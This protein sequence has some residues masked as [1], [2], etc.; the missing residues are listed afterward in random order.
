ML[1]VFWEGSLHL[2]DEVAKCILLLPKNAEI[3]I[4]LFFEDPPFFWGCFGVNPPFFK[5]GGDPMGPK[6]RGMH[7]LF[8]LWIASSGQK[9][10]FGASWRPWE[11]LLSDFGFFSEFGGFSKEARITP[12]TPSLRPQL[13]PKTK[14]K[15]L[16]GVAPTNQTEESKVCALPGKESGTVPFRNSL[17]LVSTI[18]L[19][20][21]GSRTNSGL[22]PGKFSNLTSFG[23]VCRSHS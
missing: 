5:D 1:R 16:S 8:F 11:S 3:F 12:P 14:T 13:K 9:V 10:T 2:E 18:N 6:K 21:A 22:L 23:S 7:P 4:P 20:K 19:Q 15:V 17:V